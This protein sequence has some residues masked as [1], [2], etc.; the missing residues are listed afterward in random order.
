MLQTPASAGG[1]PGRTAPE[2]KVKP[3]CLPIR[4]TFFTR[5]Q[6][7]HLKRTKHVAQFEQTPLL[8]ISFSPLE[9]TIHFVKFQ[10]YSSS[11]A[12]KGRFDWNFS[13]EP[14]AGGRHIT[15]VFQLVTPS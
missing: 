10:F 3:Q 1:W 4:V 9:V 7:G 6:L 8:L 5:F 12:A 2:N 11:S 14:G 15:F 13:L